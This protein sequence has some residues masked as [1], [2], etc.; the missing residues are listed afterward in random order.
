MIFVSKSASTQAVLHLRARQF[1]QA[2]IEFH[3]R[4]YFEGYF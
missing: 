3:I 4:A 2:I 1:D